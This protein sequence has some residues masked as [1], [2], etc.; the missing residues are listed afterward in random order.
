MANASNAAN[1]K[2]ETISPREMIRRRY[3]PDLRLTTHEGKQVRLY[4]DLIKDKLV[5]IN[6]MYSR[7]T[8]VCTPV[9]ANLRRVQ[10]MFGPRVGRD[11]FFYSFT[12]KPQEDTPEVLREHAKRLDAGPGWYFVTGAADDMEHLRRCL[13]FTDPDPA[14]DADTTNHTGIVRYGNEPLQLW[15]ACP[16]GITTPKSLAHSIS[17]VDWPER[18]GII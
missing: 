8:G 7:C 6:F 17:F 10:K 16:G 11:M 13:G 9:S 15:A 3:F 2:W 12:L 14:R 4:E 5:V 1:H 18:R